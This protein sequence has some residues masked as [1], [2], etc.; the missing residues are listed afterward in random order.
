MYLLPVRFSLALTILDLPKL[1]LFVSL[2]L[3]FFL[4]YGVYPEIHE[5][6][7]PL[8]NYVPDPKAIGRMLMKTGGPAKKKTRN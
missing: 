6:D 8:L 7:L 2:S 5:R 3:A 4:K 1:H